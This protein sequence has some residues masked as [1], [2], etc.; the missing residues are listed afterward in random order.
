MPLELAGDREM[1]EAARDRCRALVDELRRDAG[2][3]ARPSR[4]VSEGALA[5]GRAAYD[6]AAAAAEQLLRRLEQSLA[7]EP[8]NDDA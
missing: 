3:L 1:L 4:L 8:G 7:E 6:G 2:E 5:E